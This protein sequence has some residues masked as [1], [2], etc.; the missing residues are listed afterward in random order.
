MSASPTKTCRP[1]QASLASGKAPG[2]ICLIDSHAMHDVSAI[3]LIRTVTTLDLSQKAEKGM[4][5]QG[6]RHHHP[7]R[8]P[9]PWQLQVT[10]SGALKLRRKA[11]PAAYH[12]REPGWHTTSIS[13]TT[14]TTPTRALACV[15]HWAGAAA[16]VG[17]TSTAESGGGCST[18][19]ATTGAEGRA[20]RACSTWCQPRQPHTSAPQPTACRYWGGRGGGGAR[21]GVGWG[22]WQQCVDARSGHSSGHCC[23]KPAAKQWALTHTR[24]W[25]GC[26][27]RASN[28][29]CC[30]CCFHRF[31]GVFC[32]Q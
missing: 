17:H 11:L 19:G 12:S 10:S 20:G 22:V 25:D 21:R 14:S 4:L 8:H 27:S 28:Y 30:S 9:L 13:S 7:R 18:W 31:S 1:N 16:S 32:G 6:P 26:A 29:R 3:K 15:G 24:G 23:C 2:K 5:D